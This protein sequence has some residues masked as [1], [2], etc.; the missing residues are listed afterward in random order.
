LFFIFKSG[1]LDSRLLLTTL[2]QIWFYK[3]QYLASKNT[4]LRQIIQNL[5]TKHFRLT[6]MTRSKIAIFKLSHA[7]GTRSTTSSPVSARFGTFAP[8][9]VA[10][11]LV[12]MLHLLRISGASTL[13]GTIPSSSLFAATTFHIAFT[14]VTPIQPVPLWAYSNIEWRVT[15]KCRHFSLNGKTFFV[16]LLLLI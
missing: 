13:W 16:A 1:H 10:Q 11:C 2:K 7:G 4:K 12:A 5:K 3:V 8:L 14:P 9:D 6:L 15:F